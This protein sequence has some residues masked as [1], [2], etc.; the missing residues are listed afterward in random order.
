[1]FADPDPGARFTPGQTAQNDAA[2]EPATWRITASEGDARVR[3]GPDEA[4][5]WQAAAVGLSLRVPAEAE[6]GPDGWVTLVSSFDRITVTP[7]TAILLP[8]RSREAEITAIL[9]ARGTA[10]YDV[11]PRPAPAGLVEGLWTRLRRVF[12]ST[13]REPRRFEVGTPHLVA[14]VK[15]TKFRVTVDDRGTRVAVGSGLVGVTDAVSGRSLDVVAGQTATAGPDLGFG[16]TEVSTP[17]GGDNPSP[18]SAGPGDQAADDGTGDSPGQAADD[19]TGD[20]PGTGDDTGDN[21][22]PAGPS[23]SGLGD[24]SNPGLGDGGPG[25]GKG[26][27]A[28]G[29]SG[30][31]NPGGSSD[32]GGS[33]ADS[34]GGGSG[35][36]DSGSGGSGG[37]SSS[38]GG[39]GGGSAGGAGGSSG[40]PGASGAGGHGGG[41]GGG[42]GG[43]R[44]G[45]KGGGGGNGGS[46]GGQGA[47]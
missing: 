33:G 16:L 32:G 7:N 30:S 47:R 10:R 28:S 22:A 37:G 46:S 23:R 18:G 25:R 29:Q 27:T 36:G 43:G 6:T 3:T 9:Q 11:D 15:G 17:N 31:G 39:S 45:G 21:A 34:S 35:G 13:A 8:A 40:G 38:S 41:K 20:S 24:G 42:R 12:F 44:G 4:G 26:A 5:A 1:M 2:G 19:G 14:V